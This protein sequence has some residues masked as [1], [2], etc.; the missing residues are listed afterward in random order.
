[1][2][3]DILVLDPVPLRVPAYKVAKYTARVGGLECFHV[4]QQ[5]GAL[6]SSTKVS[7]LW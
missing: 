6:H 5:A 7:T 4:R 1:M 2:V 3:I